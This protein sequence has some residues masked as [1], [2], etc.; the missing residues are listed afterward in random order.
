M[1][2][3][4]SFGRWIAPAAVTAMVSGTA[5]FA[6]APNDL[7]D[8]LGQDGFNTTAPQ[9]YGPTNP[10]TLPNNIDINGVRR[11]LDSAYNDARALYT[12]LDRQSSYVPAARNYLTDILRM[13]A[14]A[15]SLSQQIRTKADLERVLPDLQALDADWRRVSFGLSGVRGLDRTATDLI[16]RLDDTGAQITKLLQIGP[17]VDYREL[18]Q[19]T[20]ALSTAMGRLI[21]DIDYDFGRTQQGRQLIADGQIVQQHATH[22][23]D[24]T[25]QQDSHEHLVA[26]FRLFQQAWSPFVERLRTLNSRFIDKDVQQVNEFARD[27]SALL[28]VE[29]TLDRQQLLYLAD[30]LTRDVDNFFDNA[31]LKIL[32]RLPEKDRALPSADAFY[33]VFENFVDCVKRGE[34]Q[35][36]LQDA[37]AYINDEWKN[38]SRV[39]RPLQSNDAQQVLNAIERDVATLS[40]ALLIQDGFDRRKAGELTALVE[41]LATY[42]ERD[43]RTWLTKARLPNASE[44][45]REV[46]RYRASAHELHDALNAGANPREVKQM[47]DALFDSWRRV[48]GYVKQCQTSERPN[49]ASSSSQT[50]PA[51]IELRTLLAR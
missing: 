50:T 20:N 21:Q 42:I 43:T 17:S 8:I 4:R 31:P 16:K 26:D 18:V 23:A 46:T 22:L 29:Q 38:F 3:I 6:Q 34:N 44:I 11:G 25:F 30:N 35:S 13:Q 40:Q 12:S 5:A 9:R 51:L 41:T 19:K 10:V 1:R 14:R 47:T 33:G 7:I 39:Y 48:Y 45:Q 49:L 2:L 27:V 37:F 36:E 15:Q 28:W 32:M 24:T